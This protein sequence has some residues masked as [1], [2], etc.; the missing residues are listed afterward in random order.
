MRFMLPE[1]RAKMREGLEEIR[2]GRFAREWAAEQEA[3]CPTLEDLREAARSLPLYQ[4]EQE[5]RQAL[6]RERLPP[7][8]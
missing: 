2:S 8:A 7:A 4:L 6:G 3:G 5:L 1:L